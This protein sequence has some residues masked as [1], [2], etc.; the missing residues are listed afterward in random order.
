MATTSNIS[1][2]LIWEIVR[3][4]HP[5]YLQRSSRLMLFDG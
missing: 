4:L 5:C 3:M 2:D 1:A